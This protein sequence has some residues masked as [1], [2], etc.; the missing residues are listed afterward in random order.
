MILPP[1]LIRGEILSMQVTVHNYLDADMSDITIRLINVT[2]FRKVNIVNNVPKYEDLTNENAIF[3]IPLLKAQSGTSVMFRIVPVKI[4]LLTLT[5]RGS[6]LLAGDTEKKTIRVKPEGV[7]KK[8]TTTVLIDMR[9]NHTYSND[10]KVDFPADIVAES[11]FCRVQLIGDFIG[12]SLNNLDKLIEIPHGCGEQNM[13][14]LTPNIYALRY[15]QSTSDTSSTISNR[16]ELIQNAKSNIK[17]GYERE[18]LYKHRDGSYSAF[19]ESDESGSSWLTGY[20]LK[21]FAQASEF[22]DV[23]DDDVLEKAISWLIRQQRSDGSFFEPG[24]ML[25][26]SMQGGV[27]SNRTITAS[28]AIALLESRLTDKKANYSLSNAVSYLESS[29]G[30]IENDRY[31]M[32][33]VT[34]ALHLAKSPLSDRAFRILKQQSYTKEG[35]MYWSKAAESNKNHDSDIELTSYALLAYL[36]R[37]LVLEALPIVKWLLSKSNSLGGYSSSQNTVIALQALSEYSIALSL[38]DQNKVNSIKFDLVLNGL[39][40]ND[41]VSDLSRS[42]ETNDRNKL[43]LQMWELPHCSFSSLTLEGS[44]SGMALFQLVNT[45]NLPKNHKSNAFTLTQTSQA[46]GNKNLQMRT[47]LTYNEVDSE[48]GERLETGMTL[49]EAYLLSGYTVDQNELDAMVI[50]KKFPRLKMV[51]LSQEKDKVT[52]YLSKMDHETMCMD[53]KMVSEFS[54]SNLQATQVKAYDYYRTSIAVSEMFWPPQFN[55]E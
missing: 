23:I 33:I 42:F 51:E 26:K 39:R 28:I 31:A 41:T 1:S 5:A 55:I 53:W 21:S 14:G 48:T 17:S 27:T 37:N 43:V 24:R 8:E 2:G 36:K 34:Y 6:S 16:D 54:V 50:S 18:L 46:Y 19:G 13:V 49:I 7:E 15:L 47:C 11:E 45:Y 40:L 38:K 44:G 30:D 35:G 12:S 29:L 25:D 10:F 4:G 9:A 32:G 22:V 20:V 52:F 3:E